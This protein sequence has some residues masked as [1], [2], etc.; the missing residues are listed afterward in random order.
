MW[1]SAPFC[2]FQP[3]TQY[4]KLRQHSGL[5]P[6]GCMSALLQCVTKQLAW[7]FDAPVT[8]RFT[9]DPIHNL[10][11]GPSAWCH[12]SNRD[13]VSKQPPQASWPHLSGMTEWWWFDELAQGSQDVGALTCTLN[14]PELDQSGGFFA[15]HQWQAT[16]GCTSPLLSGPL[17]PNLTDTCTYTADW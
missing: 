11:I 17:S 7:S 15:N 2:V 10:H 14:Q 6:A 12:C 9:S 13:K 3:S 5:C 1:R 16:V 8:L 4:C